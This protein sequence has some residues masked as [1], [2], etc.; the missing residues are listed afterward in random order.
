L[1]RS[2]G[3][4]TDHRRTSNPGPDRRWRIVLK[5]HDAGTGAGVVVRNF[6][7]PLT[8]P[9]AGR[10]MRVVMMVMMQGLEHGKA[11]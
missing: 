9:S 7:K 1:K 5:R 10:G 3:L 4:V 2:A 8:A 6:R 11:H